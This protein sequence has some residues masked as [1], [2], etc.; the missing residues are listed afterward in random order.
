MPRSLPLPRTS[1]KKETRTANAV[2]AQRAAPA[3]RWTDGPDHGNLGLALPARPRRP[4]ARDVYSPQDLSCQPLQEASLAAL[5][6]VNISIPSRSLDTVIFPRQIVLPPFLC[7][8]LQLLVESRLLG[9]RQV[10]TH[11]QLEWPEYLPIDLKGRK[12]EESPLGAIFGLDD[13]ELTV[14]NY[15]SSFR[16]DV[17]PVSLNVLVNYLPRMGLRAEPIDCCIHGVLE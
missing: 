9:S 1:S 16:S 13:D 2:A 5:Q 11:L 4:K 14:T 7:L 12:V 17:C 8:F 6:F 10:A 15:A 3:V